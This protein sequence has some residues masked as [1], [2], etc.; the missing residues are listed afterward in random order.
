MDD[1]VG[2]SESDSRTSIHTP[3]S[4]RADRLPG[5]HIQ[6]PKQRHS[7]RIDEDIP[8]RPEAQANTANKPSSPT[9]PN[10]TSDD[11][12]DWDN[13]RK[14]EV[15]RTKKIQKKERSKAGTKK[16]RERA[17]RATREADFSVSRPMPAI[18]WSFEGPES[19]DEEDHAELARMK[20]ELEELKEAQREEEIREA[21]RLQGPEIEEVEESEDE[22]ITVVTSD[23]RLA[24]YVRM[25]RE[26]EEVLGAQVAMVEQ[27]G[28]P[29][30]LQKADGEDADETEKKDKAEEHAADEK[31]QAKSRWRQK[32]GPMLKA[33]S[34]ILKQRALQSA[35]TRDELRD[36]NEGDVWDEVFRLRM[37][38]ELVLNRDKKGEPNPEEQKKLEKLE[39]R[40]RRERERIEAA[41]KGPLRHHQE[42]YERRSGTEEERKQHLDGM[43]K[44]QEARLMRERE[45][46]FSRGS[47]PSDLLE[48]EQRRMA[49][50]EERLGK[51]W[52]LKRERDG[53]EKEEKRIATA[54]ERLRREPKRERGEIEPESKK[55]A[56]RYERELEEERIKAEEERM[57]KEWE[58]RREREGLTVVTGKGKAERRTSLHRSNARHSTLEG[59]SQSQRHG[60]IQDKRGSQSP[61]LHTQH[62]YPSITPADQNPP[63]NTL[64]VKNIPASRTSEEELFQI[65]SEQPGYKRLC[66]RTKESGPMCFVEFEDIPAA[67]KA[68]GELDGWPLRGSAEGGIRLSYSRDPLGVRTGA[69]ASGEEQMVDRRAEGG[70]RREEQAKRQAEQARVITEEASKK[71]ADDEDRRAQ[72]ERIRK[73]LELR[74]QESRRSAEQEQ[75]AVRRSES[76]DMFAAPEG[77][78]GEEKAVGVPDI[79]VQDTAGEDEVDELLKEWTTVLG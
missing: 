38:L 32:L 76:A 11:G 48:L 53:R 3:V 57:K 49:A 8:T 20:R 66:F 29:K 31:Q 1:D 26:L 34:A 4:L 73:M 77:R 69:A 25:K 59:S 63:C 2:G 5:S 42:S 30:Q 65:F 18:E 54:K 43:I 37:E 78:A 62:D 67:T 15:P 17:R 12:W 55:S 6:M 22:K 40:L 10:L 14:T 47:S 58:L 16:E 51:R 56:M 70:R 41:G 60:S 27:K 19:Q 7:A 35:S 13:W 79:V 50:D 68:L 45:L 23:E 36:V 71:G 21:K 44:T 64:Y 46:E 75:V 24:N 61:F 28:E 9:Q 33:H 39:A 72:E 52:E 74:Y